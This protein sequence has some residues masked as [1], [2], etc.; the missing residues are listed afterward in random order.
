MNNGTLSL[1]T[2]HA[3]NCSFERA[4]RIYMMVEELESITN[5]HDEIFNSLFMRTKINLSKTHKK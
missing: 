4:H 1:I 5:M 3:C 2:S